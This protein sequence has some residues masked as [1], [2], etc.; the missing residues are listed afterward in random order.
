L[1]IALTPAKKALLRRC[2]SAAS[3]IAFGLGGMRSLLE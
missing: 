1:G 2:Y 3:I